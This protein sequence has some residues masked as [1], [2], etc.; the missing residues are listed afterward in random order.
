V[1]VTVTGTAAAAVAGFVVGVGAS[2]LTR[3]YAAITTWVAAWMLEFVLADFPRISGGSQGLALPQAR[4]EVLGGGARFTPV[5]QYETAL[6]MVV[7]ALCLYAA[8][9]RSPAGL[10]LAA[11]RQSESGALVLGA[12]RARL[13]TSAIV[14]SAAT[15]GLAGAL[16]V[17]VYGIADP[18]S[19][20]P[21][22][23]VKLF[24]AVIVGGAAFSLGPAVGA[25]ALVLVGPAARALGDLARI[26]PE[27]FEPVVAAV[28][29]LAAIAAGGRGVLTRVVELIRGAESHHP[30]RAG[31]SRPIAVTPVGGGSARP[32]VE[33]RGV[34]K[35]FGGV[36][37]LDD[38]ALAIEP[39]AIHAVIG[40][41][42]SG[43]STLLKILSGSLR[44]D[45]GIVRVDGELLGRSVAAARSQGIVR[46]L[47]H[48]VVFD[49]MSVRDHVVAGSV[50]ARPMAGT[51]R[52]LARTPAARAD[53]RSARADADRILEDVGLSGARDMAAGSITGA[54]QRYLM[55]AMAL[56][57]HP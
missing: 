32:I 19:Y 47:Q 54:E 8:V 4:L 31:A 35:A 28:L 48:T 22:L 16:L 10:H 11:L 9:K 17:Q 50:S 52:Y 30:R 41:N 20:G 5:W 36:R 45:S 44:P 38:V 42:G 24:V 46:T 40:P 37:A 53:E 55:I 23:S 27:R 15:G 49:D 2:R 21:L 13:R 39:G 18:T 29:L 51:V 12:N 25:I 34:T 57:A 3:V 6:F 1:A 56:A 33:A 14:A 43:K 26:S 7:F